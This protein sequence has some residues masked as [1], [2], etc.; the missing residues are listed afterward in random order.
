MLPEHCVVSHT[1]TKWNDLSP[2]TNSESCPCQWC[3]VSSHHRADCRLWCYPQKSSRHTPSPFVSDPAS[4]GPP[5][6]KPVG[7]SLLSQKRETMELL[8][9]YRNPCPPPPEA[10]AYP[11]RLTLRGGIRISQHSERGYPHYSA[12]WP[13]ATAFFVYFCSKSTCGIN[14]RC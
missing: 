5:S 11:K 3:L 1:L 2:V 14:Q 6:M 8:V 9:F 4:M 7:V 12:P 13:L 10:V